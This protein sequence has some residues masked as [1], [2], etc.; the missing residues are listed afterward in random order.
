[1][2]IKGKNFGA[3]QLS[4]FVS[5]G[6]VKAAIN[7]W[8]NSQIQAVAPIGPSG[9]VPV[10]V[11]TAEGTS[12]SKDFAYTAL[13]GSCE[14]ELPFQWPTDGGARLLG[15]DYAQFNLVRADHYHTGLD[16]GDGIERD[17]FATA[18]GEVVAV[19]PNGDKNGCVFG[20]QRFS[21]KK[22]ADNHGFQGVVILK[23]SLSDGKVRYSLYGHLRDVVGTFNPG[24][25]IAQGTR[26]GRTGAAPALDN[27]L[28]FEMKDR[29]VLHNPV[30]K[31]K[32]CKDRSGKLAPQC[33]GYT[34]AHPD[35]HG[36]HDAIKFLHN[37]DEIG[38]PR[39]VGVTE[40]AVSLRVGPG[41]LNSTEYRL[42]K[43]G[44]RRRTSSVRQGGRH[45]RS[46]LS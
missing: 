24:Q 45:I 3:T 9:I 5:F 14:A 31:P 42:L 18:K 27:H 21:R 2:T 40:D 39:P 4:S 10:T 44:Q 1:M 46:K 15:Q 12:N 34:L 26:V 41:G 38:F 30:Q 28:H 23:H 7:S 33:W 16:I 37:I 6:S 20:S 35:L 29:P 43:Y 11:T 25:C 8:T 32:S 17:V 22:S 36:Y 13:P 19:C